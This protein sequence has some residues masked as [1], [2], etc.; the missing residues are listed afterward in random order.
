MAS[1]IKQL[2]RKEAVTEPVKVQDAVAAR[3]RDLKEKA[4]LVVSRGHLT[5]TKAEASKLVIKEHLNKVRDQQIKARKAENL[6]KFDR[7]F[8][9]GKRLA[10]AYDVVDFISHEVDAMTVEAEA[11]TFVQEALR[12]AIEVQERF[13]E[14]VEAYEGLTSDVPQIIDRFTANMVKVQEARERTS[15]IMQSIRAVGRINL[16]GD[17]TPGEDTL[18]AWEELGR[19]LGLEEARVRPNKP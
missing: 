4:A 13:L 2:F 16:W 8:S 5:R 17:E 1:V 15:K 6:A 3:L 10:Q 14:T 11:H 9:Q 7:L 12:D 18:K 19:E